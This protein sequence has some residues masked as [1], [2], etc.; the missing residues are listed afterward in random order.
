MKAKVRTM[1]LKGVMDRGGHM[2]KYQLFF[3]SNQKIQELRR[4]RFRMK[5]SHTAQ[6]SLSL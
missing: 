5:F 6:A 3:V 2:K 4:E 1:K